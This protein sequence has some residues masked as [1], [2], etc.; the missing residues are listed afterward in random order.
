MQNGEVENE[1]FAFV[2]LNVVPACFCKRAISW[3]ANKE[4]PLAAFRK[5]G[6]PRYPFP[7]LSG[8]KGGHSPLSSAKAELNPT[9]LWL[10]CPLPARSRPGAAGGKVSPGQ[11]LI[12]KPG[13][14]RPSAPSLLW[15]SPLPSRAP[16]AGAHLR[17]P[18][19]TG[20][21]V[22]HPNRRRQPYQKHKSQGRSMP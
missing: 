2:S 12:E 19:G 8:S 10:F 15:C 22:T 21:E 3:D 5:Q 14:F 17:A 11:I 4:A 13:D 1:D 6:S 9:R 7:T 20:E 18:E 16:T